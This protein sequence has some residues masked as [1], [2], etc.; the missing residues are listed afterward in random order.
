MKQHLISKIWSDDQ[1]VT[2]GEITNGLDNWSELVNVK[3]A[4]APSL[5][6]EDNDERIIT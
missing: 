6:K 2:G 3:E 5:I 4:K 1:V